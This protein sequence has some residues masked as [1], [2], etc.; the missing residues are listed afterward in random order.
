MTRTG[1]AGGYRWTAEPRR[2]SRLCRIASIAVTTG[3]MLAASQLVGSKPNRSP[4]ATTRPVVASKTARLNSRHRPPISTRLFK[5]RYLTD[6]S[7]RRPA[8]VKSVAISVEGKI[9]CTD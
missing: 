2:E 4:T 1:A 8:T 5:H 3:A 7:R 6:G 9:V